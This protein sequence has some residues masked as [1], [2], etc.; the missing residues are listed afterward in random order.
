MPAYF[1][2]TLYLQGLTILGIL[3]NPHPG[4][5]TSSTKSK[6]YNVML[7]EADL[8]T[9]KLCEKTKWSSNQDNGITAHGFWF[10]KG[11][12]L[13]RL[14]DQDYFA[15]VQKANLVHYVVKSAARCRERGLESPP[16]YDVYI[17]L[18]ESSND[19]VNIV[20]EDDERA[21]N[22]EFVQKAITAVE[23]EAYSSCSVQTQF[24]LTKWGWQTLTGV[25]F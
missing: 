17:Y 5:V 3:C 24:N 20:E 15:N 21:I 13:G 25:D 23:I 10:C 2:L 12:V 19:K 14:V 7:L 1:L 4:F 8:K 11:S 16:D 9:P 6:V 22:S 18:S